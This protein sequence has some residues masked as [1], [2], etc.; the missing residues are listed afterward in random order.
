MNNNST[1]RKFNKYL[2][3]Y[4]NPSLRLIAE[5][6][7]CTLQYLT[8]WKNGKKDMSNEMLKKVDRFIEKYNKVE[9]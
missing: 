6:I 2:F 7:G 1:R 3:D 4:K 5:E 9:C 8:N